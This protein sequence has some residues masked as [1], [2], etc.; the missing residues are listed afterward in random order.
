MS[1]SLP[2]WAMLLVFLAICGAA[3]FV[4]ATFKPGTWHAEL[5]K[6]AW[7]PPNWVFAP[8]WSILYVMIA[9]AGWLVWKE[10][11]R[12]LAMAAWVAQLLF[13]ALWSWIF[14][15]LHRMGLGFADIVLLWVAIAAFVI[16]AWPISMTAALL[17][18][19]YWAW[20]S[21]A[22]ALNL[23]MWRLNA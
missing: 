11:P 4:G 12:S 1:N 19:P 15:G 6:P 22:G 23:A 7:N 16:T 14:F 3:A 21:F 2:T 18:I 10:D 9:V 17:F 5:V 13:N 20:V 8:V